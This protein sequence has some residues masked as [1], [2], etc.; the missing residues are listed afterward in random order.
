MR[1][2][3]VPEDLH[4]N[5][6]LRRRESTTALMRACLVRALA[7]TNKQ[8][9]PIKHCAARYPSD[10]LAQFITRAAQAPATTAT[11]GWA[12]ELAQS[13]VADYL[14]GLGP[15][16]AAAEIFAQALGLT[17]DRAGQ[18]RIPH[19]VAEYGNAGFVA[20]GAPIPVRQFAAEQPDALTPHKL[21]AIAVL[22]RELV[23]S[24]N[25]EKLIGDV[26]SRAT[27]RMLDEVLFDANPA[28][29]IR[30]AGLRNG[31]SV[32]AAS[33]ATES[34]R[35]FT[36]DMAKL[37]DAVAPVAANSP[38]IYV[39]SPGRALRMKLRLTRDIDGL[40]IVAS[41]AVINDLLCV[42]PAALAVIAGTTPEIEVGRESEL[43]MNTSPVDI[44][45]GGAPVGTVF[46]SDNIG[47]KVRFPVTWSRRDPRAFAWCT[48]TGW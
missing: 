4:R 17:F 11:T 42:V 26:L 29:A 35:A 15:V 20:E 33:S 25:A 12:A 43:V 22:S 34:D 47:L 37:A 41:N 23:E 6:D 21:A 48:P 16:S 30:P 19:F 24:S 8:L 36:E 28:S 2:A 9:D 44:G 14:T 45:A 3:L 32:T 1:P 7:V 27:G 40:L 46:Q 18:V 39:A 13:V 31:V 10:K 38:L 5:G